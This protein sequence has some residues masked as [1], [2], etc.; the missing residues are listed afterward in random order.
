MLCIVNRPG[1]PAPPRGGRVG[2]EA[3]VEV[4]GPGVV[5]RLR[6]AP[7]LAEVGRAPDAAARLLLGVVRPPPDHV[8]HG[9]QMIVVARVDRHRVEAR[10]AQPLARR[11]EPGPAH[12]VGEPDAVHV[13]AADH[14]VGLVLAGYHAAHELVAEAIS[15]GRAREHLRRAL[16]RPPVGGGR[17]RH[18][19]TLAVLRPVR[20]EAVGRQPVADRDAGLRGPGG[21]GVPAGA[22]GD[23]HPPA[24]RRRARSAAARRP[25]AP[26]RRSIRARRR[27]P[28][29]P[30]RRPRPRRRGGRWRARGSPGSTSRRPRAPAARRSPRPRW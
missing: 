21:D 8:A 9:E 25:P 5:H 10:A 22:R 4:V 24:P 11:V 2:E 1:P 12:G 29:G 27:P 17:R 23:V 26:P 18:G 13:A 16:D 6:E 28:P 19:E 7:G 14:E 20:P 30:R 15:L 3:L